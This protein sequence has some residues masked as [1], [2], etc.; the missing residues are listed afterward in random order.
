[1]PVPVSVKEIPVKPQRNAYDCGMFVLEIAFQL[2]QRKFDQDKDAVWAT[3]SLEWAKDLNVAEMRVFLKTHIA[4]LAS[5]ST[6]VRVLNVTRFFV[7]AL[8][9]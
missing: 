2:L 4:Q 6:P 3:K 8:C 5:E 1:M 9:N 7:F